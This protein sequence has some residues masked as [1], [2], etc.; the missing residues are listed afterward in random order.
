M[1]VR[2]EPNI[3]RAK[4]WFSRLAATQNNSSVQST[5]LTNQASAYANNAP[6]AF[7]WGKRR[8]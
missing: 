3:D 2:K 5:K 6:K 7:D 1:V 4:K 8:V